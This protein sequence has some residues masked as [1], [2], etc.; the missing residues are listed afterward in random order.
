MHDT[1]LF[2]GL[3]ERMK[4][5]RGGRDHIFETLEARRTALIVVDVQ[6]FFC[7][8]ETS[9]GQNTNDIVP[10]VNQLADGVRTSGGTVVWI[11]TTFTEE[12]TKSWSTMF[13]DFCSPPVRERLLSG[14]GPG[15]WG[16][17]LHPHLV[18]KP[19]DLTVEKDRFSPFIADA[20]TLHADLQARGIDTIVITGTE[21][22][23]CCESTARDGMM[24]NYKTIMVSDANAAHD[25][26]H[27]NSALSNVFGFVDVMTTDEV[28]SR[29]VPAAAQ[30]A[31]E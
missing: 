23:V 8:P 16:H 13:H 2:P 27:H 20:S 17:A 19:G 28:L 21:T 18:V 9:G 12:T 1:T 3:V 14:L 26:N 4:K 10:A 11:I 29:L 15:G 7:D 6:G 31:A 25:D 24:L 30:A 5:R 22:N